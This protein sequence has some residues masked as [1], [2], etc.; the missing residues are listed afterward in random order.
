[1]QEENFSRTSWLTV[2]WIYIS[3]RTIISL[4]NS[5]LRLCTRQFVINQMNS[6]Q[7]HFTLFNDYHERNIQLLTKTK[8]TPVHRRCQ[9]YFTADFICL[10]TCLYHV[11]KKYLYSCNSVAKE[12]MGKTLKGF[13]S[14]FKNKNRTWLVMRYGYRQFSDW[15]LHISWLKS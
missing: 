6:F 14:L 7:K 5:L 12:I 10:Y 1:M 11:Q 13:L 9:V 3:R 15:H 4:D 2:L 8:K